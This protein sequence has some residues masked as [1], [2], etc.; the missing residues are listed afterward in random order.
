[1]HTTVGVQIE[2]ARAE[3]SDCAICQCWRLLRGD[4]SLQESG[5]RFGVGDTSTWFGVGAM[6]LF[7]GAVN[8]RLYGEPHDCMHPI[9]SSKAASVGSCTLVS[10]ASCG[11]VVLA[12][13]SGTQGRCLTTAQSTCVSATRYTTVDIHIQCR[14]T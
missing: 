11:S 3:T 6:G 8:L 4:G 2:V 5:L 7:D 10:G 12:L 13:A 14:I 1:M 9:E